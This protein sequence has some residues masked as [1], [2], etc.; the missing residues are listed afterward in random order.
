MRILGTKM[1]ITHPVRRTTRATVFV[2]IGTVDIS[3]KIAIPPY[4]MRTCIDKL[5]KELD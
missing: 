1:M 5:H 2:A 4:S 3:D